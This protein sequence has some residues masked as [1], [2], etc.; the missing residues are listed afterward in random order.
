MAVLLGG[1]MDAL[2]LRF[3]E[4]MDPLT[5]RFD[6]KIDALTL[7]FDQQA[8]GLGTEIQEIREALD[9]GVV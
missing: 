6:E 7:R 5:L 4:S 1:K 8:I 3:D 2:P 9:N